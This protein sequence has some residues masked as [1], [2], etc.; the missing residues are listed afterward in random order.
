MREIAIDRQAEIASTTDSM[1][2]AG[3]VTVVAREGIDVR[4]TAVTGEVLS[5]DDLLD[6]SSPL[7]TGIFSRVAGTRGRGSAGTLRIAT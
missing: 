7:F 5:G 6:S 2:N 3:S 4:G 1:G